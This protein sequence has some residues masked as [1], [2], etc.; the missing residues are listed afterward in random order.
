MNGGRVPPPTDDG[1]SQDALQSL[2]LAD[3]VWRDRYEG[4][5]ELGHGSSA[6]VVRTHSTVAGEDIAVKVFTRTAP[7]EWAR[8]Q[9]EVRNAQSLASPCIVRTYSPFRRG[10][11][12]WIELELVE[13][14]DLRHALETRAADGTAFP[15]PEA[16]AIA[17][18]LARALQAAHAA[19]VVHRDVKPANVL[20]PASGTP[21][22]KLGDFGTSRLAGGARAT[23]TGLLAGTPQF[24]APEVVQGG[25]A[26]PAA[27]VYSFSLCLY[28]L[29]SNGRFP[30]SVT[31]EAPPVQW[32]RAQTD[33]A[34][35]P[36]TRFR[37]GVPA[38]LAQLL[39]R[40]LAKDPARRPSAAEALA[41]LEGGAP[42]PQEPRTGRVT[43]AAM[44]V[45]ALAAAGLTWWMTR[46]ETPAPPSPLPSPS[47][48][49]PVRAVPT[50][51]APPPSAAAPATA[52]PASPQPV[53][54]PP[55]L[56]ASLQ[57]DV[58]AL[59][60]DGP[61]RV[62]DLLIVLTTAEGVRHEARVKDG[63][64][65]GEELYLALEDFSPPVRA[66][67]ATGRAQVTLRDHRGERVTVPLRLP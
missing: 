38:W 14:V 59:R 53:A 52:P 31:D 60:S 23:R 33:E 50:P 1:T 26:G 12:A 28:L 42:L 17:R 22:A 18:D 62:D 67:L 64:A 54:A 44:A 49:T 56:G 37:E 65:P 6:T 40:G 34:P 19:G 46:G 8:F 39:E 36:V 30:F 29:L 3:P 5:T 66:P 43:G 51:A 11:L 10:A 27:D 9:Q 24:C 58:L 32:L 20:L 7:E 55:R 41:V 2:C 35:V 16:L 47:V 61:E 15:L 4:W 25:A 63:L 48:S 21:A 45:L 13:G 57:G